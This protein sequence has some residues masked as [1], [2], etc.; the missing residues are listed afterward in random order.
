[1]GEEMNNKNNKKILLLGLLSALFLIYLG[2]F[3][4]GAG[5]CVS[6]IGCHN[7]SSSLNC[8]TGNVTFLDGQPCS[9][10][11]EPGCCCDYGSNS[12]QGNLK[13]F[14]VSPKT[15]VSNP[16]VSIG[17]GC[18]CGGNTFTVAGRIE[19]AAG[20]YIGG[21][22]V[23]IP[24]IQASNTTNMDGF[25]SIGNV[26]ANPQL[27][28][29]AHKPS[30]GCLPNSVSI[31]LNQDKADVNI[32]LNCACNPGDCNITLNAVCNYT[33][34]KWHVYN[35]AD[36]GERREYCIFCGDKDPECEGSALCIDND[37]KCPPGCIPITDSDCA[38]SSTPN[39][40]C[41]PG[42]EN[43][44]PD[45]TPYVA[46]CGNGIITYPYETC[47]DEPS[48]GQMSL[49]N[50]N[51]CANPQ[52]T[53]ACNCRG[54]SGCGN[55]ILEPSEACEIGMICPGGTPCENCQCGPISCTGTK[56]NPNISTNFDASNKKIIISWSLLS[57]CQ[58]SVISYS[59]FKCDVS[60]GSCASKS[61]GFSYFTDTSVMLA[62]DITI[63]QNS[64]YCY[65]VKANYLGS[66]TGESGIACQK[67]G[68]SFCM[69]PHSKEFCISNIRS[70]CDSS[71]NIK[72]ISGGD[73]NPKKYCVGPDR[74]GNTACIDVGLCDLCNGLYG[75]YSN[76]DLRVDEDKLYCYLDDLGLREVV[77]GCY[78][79]RTKTLFSAFDYCANVATC[80][81]YKSEAACTDSLDP[82]LKNKGCEWVWLNSNVPALSGICRPKVKELQRC[83]LCDDPAYNWLST[84]CAPVVCSL[85]GEC[86][87]Q[88]K[89]LSKLTAPTCSKRSTASCLG[90]ATQPACTGGKPVSVDA[91]YD[92]NGTRISGTHLLTTASNDT[93][94]LGKCFWDAVNTRCRRNAD[95]YPQ[96]NAGLFGYDCAIGDIYCEADFSSPE[97]IILPTTFGVYPANMKILFTT[98][99]NYPGKQI[100]TYFC[101]SQ[102]D[103]YPNEL[104]SS[105]VY[106]KQM[107][108]SGAHTLSYYS[109][110]LAKNL[111]VVKHL[112][113]MVDAERPFI[114]L[115]NPAT[116][117]TFPTNQL[118]VPIEGVTS[119]DS[120]W[121]CAKNTKTNQA[122]CINNCALTGS[123]QPC[124]PD[125]T[126]I[127]AL[128]IPVGST[129]NLTQVLFSAEDFA[130][131]TYQNTLLGILLDIEPP[132][133]P[134]I[135]ISPIIS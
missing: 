2:F 60:Q 87:Y 27:Q 101:V 131:N 82:C 105:G 106:Q 19:R 115:T 66:L 26:P 104:A 85:F 37:M 31:N 3:A 114:D 15:F 103:C 29:T 65:Y 57:S 40:V 127:F 120:K 119:V 77:S 123:Q 108:I 63:L 81:D 17:G 61:E 51:D 78:L 16:N 42:C 134:N 135:T 32:I 80:Y 110:D 100:K 95:N 117:D 53:D 93:L 46:T 47:E 13:Y 96:G 43:V 1:M 91:G 69:E 128:T 41:P 124:F 89:S 21:A 56:L 121:V 133:E 97:T 92:A 84:G 132:T 20:G 4:S 83:E 22:T 72:P 44:D 58:P 18:S 36:L 113:V 90:Y 28:V 94:R 99:D 112:T 98:S 70:Y 33:T 75:M 6:T 50:A 24:S 68:S 45:C 86:Y 107:T 8:S 52:E 73:C 12:G 126:G 116:T 23:S 34:S 64:E 7:V 74:D 54:L 125:T 55:L 9:V 49:C 76:L 118:I 109:E 10:P 5:C 71:N 111:E 129:T 102:G 38:C 11:C 79:D 62:N 48:E 67:T 14:C 30:E 25:Y 35:W 88:G 130:G 59:V 122:V 39:G